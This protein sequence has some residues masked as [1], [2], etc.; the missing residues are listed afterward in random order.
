MVLQFDNDNEHGLRL[1]KSHRPGLSTAPLS[2]N[3]R[4]STGTSTGC[5]YHD[6]A[7]PEGLNIPTPG[8]LL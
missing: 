1:F 6:V 2:T 5:A 7:T 8:R 3:T 4:K